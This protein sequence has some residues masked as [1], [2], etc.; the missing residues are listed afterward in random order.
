MRGKGHNPTRTLPLHA[1]PSEDNAVNEA[2]S[3]SA[4]E[5]RDRGIERFDTHPVPLSAEGEKVQCMLPGMP[6][7]I[8]STCP[9]IESA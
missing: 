3:L 2:P 6:P 4:E 7:S 1:Y 8:T 5:G 9:V